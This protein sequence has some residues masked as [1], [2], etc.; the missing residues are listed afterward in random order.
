MLTNSIITDKNLIHTHKQA[1]TEH[2][3]I[4]TPSHTILKK[5]RF[6]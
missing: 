3:V 4:F 2:K 5:G 1:K 6:K